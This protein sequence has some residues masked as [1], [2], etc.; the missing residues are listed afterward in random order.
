LAIILRS[1]LSWADQVIY[2]VKK[3]WKAFHVIMLI[4]KKGCSNTKSLAYTSLVRAILKYASSCWAI[5]RERQ[6][7][8]LDRGKTKQLNLHIRGMI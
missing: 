3:V 8:V 5:K 7:N 6:M 2:T 4:L 1:D